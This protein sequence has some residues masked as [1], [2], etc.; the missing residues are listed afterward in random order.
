[1]SFFRIFKNNTKKPPQKNNQFEEV[2][3]IQIDLQNE[4]F[5]PLTLFRRTG[6]RRCSERRTAP[7]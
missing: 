3:I 1:M 2:L 4:S 7:A 6:I 5:Y